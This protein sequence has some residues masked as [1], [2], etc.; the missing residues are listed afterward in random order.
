MNPEQITFDRLMDFR[1]IVFDFDGTLCDTVLDIKKAFHE[2]AIICGFRPEQ[3]KPIPVGP[4]LEAS[5][6]QAVGDEVETSMMERLKSE[7]RRCY[8]SSDFS[9][10]PLYPGAFELLTRLKK[11]GKRLALATNKG[12]ESTRRIL[13]VKEIAAL[14][15]RVLCCDSDN[16]FWSK[17]RM[18]R[19]ILDA[20][21]TGNKEAVFFGDARGDMSAGRQVDV[22]TVAVLYGYGTADELLEIGPDYVC[23]RLADIIEQ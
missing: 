20:T 6:R 4:P 15:D 10:S 9:E 7:Y 14:F 5:I 2:A 22:A 23:E 13:A 1:C 3:L 12:E 8:D 21:E 11:S 17:E 16:E 19:D 18:L